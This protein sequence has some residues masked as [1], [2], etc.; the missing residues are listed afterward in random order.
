M[1]NHTVVIGS[2]D[3]GA[4]AVRILQA[5]GHDVIGFLDEDPQQH[6]RAVDGMPVLGGTAWLDGNPAGMTAF[7]AIGD[8]AARTRIARALRDRGVTVEN[9]VHPSAVVMAGSHLGSGIFLGPTAV[10]VT[11][12]R[13]EDDVIV[14]TAATIDHG[15]TL[16]AGAHLA[17]GVH[18]AGR[19]TVG[20]ESLI[21]VGATLSTGV[22][23]G[24]SSVVGAGAVV[25]EEVPDRVVVAGVPARVFRTLDGPIDWTALLSPVRTADV[26]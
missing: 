16:R 25:L 22:R 10:V 1:P 6:G 12:T 20:R 19:V 8:N 15:C 13:I 2:G 14:N 11:G 4:V 21:G 18:A 26:G 9:A 17:P 7:V 23:V 24:D 3:H 5:A